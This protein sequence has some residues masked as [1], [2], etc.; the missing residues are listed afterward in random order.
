MTP[1]PNPAEPLSDAARM[2]MLMDA[3]ETA[4]EELGHLEAER[5]D[6]LSRLRL[7]EALLA[8]TPVC[9]CM[10]IDEYNAARAAEEDTRP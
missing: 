9:D 4:G 3:L 2:A 10:D 6:A 5:D 7:A 8:E 1:N